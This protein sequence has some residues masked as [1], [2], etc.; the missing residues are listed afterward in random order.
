MFTSDDA[1]MPISSQNSPPPSTPS[2]HTRTSNVQAVTQSQGAPSGTIQLYS[3]TAH[4]DG[5]DYD[6]TMST[7]DDAEM[8]IPLQNSPPLSTPPPNTRTSN[9]QAVTLSQGAPSG[10]IQL[11]SP[12]AHFDGV[13]DDP[14][15][16]TYDDLSKVTTK[17]KDENEEDRT[18]R[19]TRKWKSLVSDRF[20]NKS[21]YLA[22][23]CI[24]SFP[25]STR[26]SVLHR[27][28]S[29]SKNLQRSSPIV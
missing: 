17:L 20:T 27:S 23:C 15:M 13:D 4:F 28:M 16:S 19:W 7:Y 29:L 24:L 6:P 10:T 11:Y 9:V 25:T 1:E 26:T 21:M 12:T 18:K 5:V 22:F 8:P 2:P 14:T 3:P